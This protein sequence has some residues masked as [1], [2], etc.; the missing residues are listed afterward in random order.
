MHF[1]W[2]S[3][4]CYAFSWIERQDGGMEESLFQT[5]RSQMARWRQI[6]KPHHAA[7]WDSHRA[8]QIEK[9]P[10]GFLLLA[11]GRRAHMG[12]MGSRYPAI[13]GM[14]KERNGTIF[15]CFPGT[16]CILLIR[17]DYFKEWNGMDRNEFCWNKFA[18]KSKNI[19]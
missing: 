19:K 8:S 15:D 11:S 9:W 12:Q 6:G 2:I 10:S 16:E 18:R 4:I 1:S 14:Y 17:T 3:L 13:A 5:H 7:R